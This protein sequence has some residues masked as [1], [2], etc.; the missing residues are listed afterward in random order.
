MR[1][2]HANAPENAPTPLFPMLVA[3]LTAAWQPYAIRPPTVDQDLT[4]LSGIERSAEVL[5]YVSLQLEYAL[6]PGGGLRAWL[7]L[8]LLMCFL[9]SLPAILVVPVITWVLSTFT[10]WS[11]FV[12][13]AALNLLYTTLAVAA[14]VAVAVALGHGLKTYAEYIWK[15]PVRRNRYR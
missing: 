11:A 12:F 7:R 15:N 4:C 2:M 9:L 6:S 5:R 14:I 13:Q 1:T 10:T 3:A 8:N